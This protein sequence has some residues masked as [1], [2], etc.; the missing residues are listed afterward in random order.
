[1]LLGYFNKRRNLANTIFISILIPYLLLCLTMGGFHNSIFS[2]H[3]CDHTE[4][5]VS[6]GPDNHH[7]VDKKDT[8]QH[9]AE[10]CQICQWLKTPSTSMHFLLSNTQ[11]DFIYTRVIYYSNHVFPSLSIQKFTIRPPPSFFC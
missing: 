1:M 4:H 8:S 3:H 10:T 6:N 2:S 7:I 11:S 9:N 5:L